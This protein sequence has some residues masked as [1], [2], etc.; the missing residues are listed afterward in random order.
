MVSEKVIDTAKKEI[1][2][3][4]I[5]ERVAL[6]EALLRNM[7]EEIGTSPDVSFYVE[8]WLKNKKVK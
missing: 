6:L 2:G 8:R 5:I 4:S 1:E 7:Q 3:K